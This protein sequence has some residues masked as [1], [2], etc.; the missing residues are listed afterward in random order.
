MC[1]RGFIVVTII[2]SVYPL[3]MKKA[4]GNHL[5]LCGGVR[6]GTLPILSWRFLFGWC[7]FRLMPKTI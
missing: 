4:Y 1:W 6:F 7:C 2:C 3:G 5:L